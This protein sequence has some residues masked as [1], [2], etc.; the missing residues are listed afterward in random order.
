M[1]DTKN[2][3]LFLYVGFTTTYMQ[4]VPIITEVVNSNPAQA[5]RTRYNIMWKS[6]CDMYVGFS[7]HSGFLQKL[8]HQDITEILLKMALNTIPIVLCL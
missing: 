5:R 7:G 3:F 6:P 8:N 2:I 1:F 4:S